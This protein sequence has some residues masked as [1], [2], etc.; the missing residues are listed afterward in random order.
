MKKAIFKIWGKIIILVLGWKVDDR[1]KGECHRCVVVA[2]PHTSNW[3][4]V[5]AR[6]AFEVLDIPVRFTIKKEWTQSVMGSLMIA[7]GAIPI[8]RQHSKE[9]RSDHFSYVDA[10]ADLFSRYKELAILVT[11]EG[12]R[13]RN[14]TWKT[15][16]YH[17]AK[18][19]GVPIALGYLDYKNKVAGIGKILWPGDDMEADMREIM[20]FYKDA[21]PK[22]PDNF[23]LDHRYLPA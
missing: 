7:L 10:M 11:P 1:L 22:Y 6:S 2:A 8:D 23:A 9:E 21:Y 14:D 5:I 13:A 3:D 16:F 19:A 4:F 18:K 20:A 12:T 17:V 15:G